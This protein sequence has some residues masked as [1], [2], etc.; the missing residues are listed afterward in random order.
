MK[1][2]KNKFL[3]ISI[4]FL[5]AVLSFALLFH[6]QIRHVNAQTIDSGILLPHSKSEYLD[7][8]T[9]APKFSTVYDSGAAIV[10]ENNKLYIYDGNSYVEYPHLMYNNPGQIRYFS[11]NLLLV[12]D[13]LTLFTIDLNNLNSAPVP[14]LTEDLEQIP[15]NYFDICGNYMVSLSINKVTL[16]ELNGTSVSQSRDI[17]EIVAKY[18]T[19]VC[20][21]ESGKIF[22]IRSSDSKLCSF[23]IVTTAQPT[24][25]TPSTDGI[26]NM[27]SKN[28]KLYFTMNNSVWCIGE[29]TVEADNVSP[30]QL[31][32]GNEHSAFDLGYFA[33]PTDMQFYGDNFIIT[34]SQKGAIQE[35]S[36][37]ND[38][39]NFTGRAIAEDKTAFNR[40]SKQSSI[41]VKNKNTIAVLDDFKLTV[42]DVASSFNTY[43]KNKFSNYFITDLNNPSMVALGN[44][45]LLLGY[46]NSVKYVCLKDG[47]KS[48]DISV[49]YLKSIQFINDKFYYL[50]YN[51]EKSTVYYSNENSSDLYSFSETNIGAK[52]F[53]VDVFGNVYLYDDLTIYKNGTSLISNADTVGISQLFTDLNGNLFSVKD[54]TIRYF[55]TN[56]INWI[57]YFTTTGKINC[58]ANDVNTNDI[59]YLLENNEFIH[60]IKPENYASISGIQVP[61]SFILS[62]GSAIDNLKSYSVNPDRIAYAVNAN[63]KFSCIGQISPETEYAYITSAEFIGVNGKSEYVLLAGINSIILSHNESVTENVITFS[64][65][66]PEKTYIATDVNAYYLPLITKSN[67][68]PLRNGETIIR[69]KKGDVVSPLKVFNFSGLDFYFAKLQYDGNEIFGYIPVNFTVEILTE[70]L[71]PE[72]YKIETVNTTALYKDVTLS[73][74]ILDISEGEKVKVFEIVD[75][76]AKIAVKTADGYIT[77]YIASKDIQ[78]AP[79]MQIRNIL[80]ILAVSACLCGSASFFI[81]RKKK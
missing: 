36:V 62:N 27:L 31:I 51:G 24:I 41:I 48:E 4:L 46:S 63:G 80:I 18:Q 16:F 49:P 45:Y 57:E 50:T 56:N 78:D 39:L 76:I 20:V 53:T 35:F 17:N 23:D 19:P 64:T 5:T 8:N 9:S 32:C 43:D 44:E 72:S 14:F 30:T 11:D 79:N 2:L 47:T 68:Y 60:I 1:I 37:V 81:L 77:G 54:N 22:F 15:S 29:N 28:G 69:L 73:E 55:D 71:I 75:G 61:E 21:N 3:L 25:L 33:T 67:T 7:L 10:T 40:I 74:H 13:N 42:I 26:K 70:S 38:T 12:N 34:D 66:I 65:E 58:V 6:S 52:N 59:Y